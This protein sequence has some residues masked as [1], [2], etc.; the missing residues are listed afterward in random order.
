MKCL[1]LFPDL[2]PGGTC[3]PGFFLDF[4]YYSYTIMNNLTLADDIAKDRGYDQCQT[5]KEA[6]ELILETAWFDWQQDEAM[7]WFKRTKGWFKD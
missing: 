2:W 6:L 4:N 3:C 1:N 7:D 5:E